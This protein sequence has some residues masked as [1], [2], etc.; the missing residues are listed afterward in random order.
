M[1]LLPELLFQ[2]TSHCG[3]LSVY[4]GHTALQRYDAFLELL[5]LQEKLYCIYLTH[6]LSGLKLL[7]LGQ[8][9]PFYF[10]RRF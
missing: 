9:Q 3:S 10:A 7:S 5:L 2:P 4:V 8:V 6:C 1:S